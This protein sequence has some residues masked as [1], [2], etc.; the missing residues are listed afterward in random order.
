VLLLTALF[1]W[2]CAPPEAIGQ[3]CEVDGDCRGERVCGPQRVCVC[4]PGLPPP[5]D[6]C[7]ADQCGN[8]LAVGQPCS[9]GGGECN[10]N[11]FDGAF[12]CTRDFNPTDL[13]FCTL[14]CSADDD[15]GE[16]ARCAIDPD[17]PGAG[18]GC[19]PLVCDDDE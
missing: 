4:P 17:D 18:A 9:E 2:S 11:G 7:L 16:G 3:P 15:C 8:D 12:L 13:H 19:F 14:P 5:S 10:P 6:P 1:A